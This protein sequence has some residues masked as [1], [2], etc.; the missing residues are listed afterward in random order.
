[1]NPYLGKVIGAENRTED[2]GQIENRFLGMM[3]QGLVQ[4]VLGSEP[5]ELETPEGCVILASFSNWVRWQG[6]RRLKRHVNNPNTA[7]TE[8]S[9]T[10]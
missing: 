6:Y 4:D 8:G 10:G 7:R 9:A 1:M 5:S 2:L 3:L